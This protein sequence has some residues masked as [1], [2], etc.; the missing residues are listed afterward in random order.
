MFSETF[1]YMIAMKGGKNKQIRKQTEDNNWSGMV[2][3]NYKRGKTNE[4]GQGENK[5]RNEV[6]KTR[7]EEKKQKVQEKKEET[8]AD[9]GQMIVSIVARKRGERVI[10]RMTIKM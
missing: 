8:A 6:E 4:T 5:R 9:V 3:E 1:D 2:S 10:L 7:S